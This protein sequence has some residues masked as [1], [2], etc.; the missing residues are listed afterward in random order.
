VEE[1]EDCIVSV[2]LDCDEVSILMPYDS[3]HL[4]I[5][6]NIVPDGASS[7]IIFMVWDTSI[8]CK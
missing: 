1:C 2:W 3:N 7:V 8:V 6:V 4:S 5:S